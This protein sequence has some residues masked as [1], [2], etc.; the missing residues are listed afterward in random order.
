MDDDNLHW[1]YWARILRRRNLSE[2]IAI[3]LESAGPM[4]ILLAQLIYIG[5]P[6]MENILPIGQWGKIA[7]M[8]N[9]REESRKFATFLRIGDLN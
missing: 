1:I 8:L 6:L 2:P 5:Q 9:T 3:I 4:M 7:E